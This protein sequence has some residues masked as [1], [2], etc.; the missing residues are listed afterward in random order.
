MKNKY[1][2]VNTSAPL[3]P[4][5]SSTTT[6]VIVVNEGPLFVGAIISLDNNEGNGFDFFYSVLVFIELIPSATMWTY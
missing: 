2:I 6:N 1:W 3:T 5:I 4:V